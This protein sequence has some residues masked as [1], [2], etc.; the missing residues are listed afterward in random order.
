MTEETKIDLVKQVAQTTETVPDLVETIIEELQKL[1]ALNLFWAP[2][3]RS[4]NEKT[5][6]LEVPKK[7]MMISPLFKG[8]VDYIEREGWVGYKDQEGN[9]RVQAP[10]LKALAKKIVKYAK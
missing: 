4:F 5:T 10:N 2:E 1:G 8:M 7:F 6:T 9:V 3:N